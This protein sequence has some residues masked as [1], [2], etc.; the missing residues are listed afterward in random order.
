MLVWPT[1]YPSLQLAFCEGLGAP[2]VQVLEFSSDVT[3]FPEWANTP[4]ECQKKIV[5][6]HQDVALTPNGIQ[7]WMDMPCA[8]LTPGVQ[9]PCW[10]AFV[11]RGP[12]IRILFTGHWLSF[13]SQFCQPRWFVES[14]QACVSLGRLWVVWYGAEG[15]IAPCVWLH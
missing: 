12:T 6:K 1:S 13:P 5:P 15:E 11:T 9:W 2:W 10:G 14:L 8:C 7:E 4:L 3:W